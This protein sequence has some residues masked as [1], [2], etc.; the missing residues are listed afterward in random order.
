MAG[1]R[2]AR[3][4]DPNVTATDLAMM[5]RAIA[6]ASKAAAIGEVPVGAVV[7]KGDRIV[8][9]ASN[10]REATRDPVGHA[11]L[12]AM[13]AAGKVLGDWRLIDCSLAV[14]LEPCPMC[15]GAMVN[16]RLGRLIYGTD[17]PKA[18]ACKTLFHIPTDERLN[19]RVT[20]IQGVLA[21]RCRQQLREFFQQR[22]RQNKQSQKSRTA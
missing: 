20:I 19:H 11:E 15:A 13:S 16:A 21:D 1:L 22:R 12:L 5:E 14:T 10:N 7:Y 17:D 4:N 6:L 9:E 8:A 18:G 2:L 3:E